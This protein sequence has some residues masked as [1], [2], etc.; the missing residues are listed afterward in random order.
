[1]PTDRDELTPALTCTWNKRLSE[2]GFRRVG[3][4]NLQSL[5]GSI[6]RHFN[7]QVSAWGSRDFCINVAAFTL[8]GNDIPVLTPGFRLSHD[9]GCDLWL[10]SKSA[11]E[12]KESVEIAWQA[13][14]AQAL[15][16]FDRNATLEGHLQVLRGQKRGSPHHLHF[17]MGVVE[18]MLGRREEA[19]SDLTAASI[20]YERDGRSWCH[21]IYYPK[22]AALIDALDRGTEAALLE[23]W[24]VANLV[25]HRVKLLH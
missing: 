25:V 19:K 14:R 22:A 3:R 20:L 8:C 11:E 5:S 12:A 13:A 17:Q 6:L 18:A 23:Q 24:R 9:N 10:P 1:V 4:R 2:Y 15:P 16:W 7:F 21:T